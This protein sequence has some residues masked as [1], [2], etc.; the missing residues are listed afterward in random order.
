MAND[1]PAVP[2]QTRFRIDAELARGGMATVFAAYDTTTRQR[3]ALKR[4]EPLAVARMG[5][6]FEREFAVLSSLK[7]PCIVDV[8]EYG[9]DA[10]G[11]FY[12]M[13]LLEG[14]DLRELAPLP[15]VAACRYLRDVA[16]SLALLHARRLLH[17]DVSPRNVRTLR[18]GGCKLIDFGALANF[19]AT[20][21]IVGT[22]PAIPPEALSGQALD[23]RADLFA[24]GALAYFVLTGQHAYP[25]RSVRALPDSWAAPLAPPSLHAPDIPA[26][27]D[28]LVL[29][30]LNLDA[31][32]RPSNAGEVIERLNV[33]AGLAPDHDERVA[34][35]YF[36]GT[37]LVERAR[38]SRRTQRCLRLLRAGRG[39][40]LFIEGERGIGKTRLLAD[41]T[42]KGQLA[43]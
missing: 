40:A 37:T 43:G 35:A 22:P 2:S 30:L 29:G 5:G 3:V 26:A 16:S 39:R 42:L 6:L 4:L 14:A 28:A 17:R 34:R 23:Q 8:Y 20:D 25:A 21:E 31:L 10:T 36:V 33:I 27:L 7:H 24:L 9:V 19:G 11:P 38:E 41:V 13:E 18:T 1:P 32:A 12:T 15:V